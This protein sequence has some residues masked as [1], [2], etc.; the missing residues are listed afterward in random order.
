M[1]GEAGGEMGEI[2]GMLRPLYM[3]LIL[4]DKSGECWALFS[5]ER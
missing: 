4:F 3:L 1:G 5:G 2:L